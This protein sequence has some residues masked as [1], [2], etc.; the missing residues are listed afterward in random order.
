M[1][2]G[3]VASQG[4]TVVRAEIARTRADEVS[5][6]SG[7]SAWARCDSPGWRAMLSMIRHKRHGEALVDLLMTRH[8]ACPHDKP[9]F[10]ERRPYRRGCAGAALLMGLVVASV[11]CTDGIEASGTTD[12]EQQV[13]PSAAGGDGHLRFASVPDRWT[14][15]YDSPFAT[16]ALNWDYR[17]LTRGWGQA[18]VFK[19]RRLAIRA[20]VLCPEPSSPAA[21]SPPMGLH[22]VDIR[23]NEGM[24]GHLE[25]VPQAIEHRFAP[26]VEGYTIDL[27]VIF[28]KRSIVADLSKKAQRVVDGGLVFP[29]RIECPA[30]RSK[31]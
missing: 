14:Q 8:D 15:I 1:P 26:R 6:P 17:R 16:T 21:S 30:I 7:W 5:H 28:A 4:G 31:G 29:G 18:S 12:V 24:V 20:I 3:P 13:P 10:S 22:H 27:R 25:G 19:G 23:V 11:G 9:D 2:S